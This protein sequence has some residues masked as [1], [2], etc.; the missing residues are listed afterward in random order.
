MQPCRPPL[1]EQ[2]VSASA[3][4][5]VRTAGHQSIDE[6]SPVTASGRPGHDP[7]TAA[8]AR[9][10]AGPGGFRCRRGRRCRRRGARRRRGWSSTGLPGRRRPL[11]SGDASPITTL[12]RT[13]AAMTPASIVIHFDRT[14]LSIGELLGRSL[15]TARRARPIVTPMDQTRSTESCRGS[16][17]RCSDCGGS[18]SRSSRSGV[19]HAS[20]RRMAY[21]VSLQFVVRATIAL[22][23]RSHPTWPMWALRVPL[24]GLVSRTLML[25]Y[26]MSC[27]RRQ[28][29]PAVF[30]VVGAPCIPGASSP[31]P[32]RAPHS[33]HPIISSCYDLFPPSSG[34]VHMTPSRPTS[35]CVAASP[36][37]RATT[38]RTR[39]GGS[40]SSRRACR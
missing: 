38:C 18:R 35:S 27:R 21:F 29:L 37:R 16:T 36:C 6:P 15:V 31:L 12:T 19:G 40:R 28:I 13:T 17:S 2:L 4:P 23:A 9:A 33:A 10:A 5:V 22:F 26:E 3:A 34:F 1:P 14:A 7:A 11:P 20:F 39:R 25:A 32:G 24:A 8:G 30:A